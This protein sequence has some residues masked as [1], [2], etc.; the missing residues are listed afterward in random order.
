MNND[1][2]DISKLANDLKL[3]VFARFG[4]YVKPGLPFEQNLL[5]LLREQT[6]TSNEARVMRRVRYAGFPILKTLD[7]LEL[8]QER[9]PHLNIDELNELATCRFIEEKADVAAIGPPGRG[10]THTAIAIGYEALK[11][12]FSVRFKRASD[13]VSEMSEAKSEK[14]LSDYSRALNRCNLLIIDELGFLPYDAN[15]SSFLFQIIS[16]RYE[17]ASTIYTT[18]H[19]FSKWSQFI[20][21]KAIVSAIIDRI[22]HHSIILNMNGPKAWRLEHARSRVEGI[23]NE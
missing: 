9:F 2:L 23:I 8:D 15:A 14:K 7:T 10:K 18:N 12:G 22:A 17:T 1:R 3:P 6:A 21:D 13:L 5:H 11:H 19:P 4:D 16:A 20:T